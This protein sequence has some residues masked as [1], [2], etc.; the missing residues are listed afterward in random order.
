[1]GKEQ[2]VRGT[3]MATYQYGHPNVKEYRIPCFIK[4]EDKELIVKRRALVHLGNPELFK[5]PY[6]K[7][8]S[9]ST[10]IDKDWSGGKR[11]AK[12]PSLRGAIFGARADCLG[13]TVKGQ[14]KEGNA[15]QVP[16]LFTHVQFS[17][18]LKALID[19]KIA[20][21]RGITI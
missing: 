17:V 5:I 16:I 21:E 18:K 1:M 7:I 15:V 19:R 13:L 4:V 8:L 2:K 3:F 9:V 10:D 12:D 11:L 20:E 6:E 14:D